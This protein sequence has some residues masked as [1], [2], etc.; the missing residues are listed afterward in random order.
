MAA[1]ATTVLNTI[2]DT[3]EKVLEALVNV[4]GARSSPTCARPSTYVERLDARAAHP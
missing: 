4:A 3:Q 1:P 2:T